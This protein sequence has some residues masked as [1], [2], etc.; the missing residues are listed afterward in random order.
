MKYHRRRPL[1]PAVHG[2]RRRR[3]GAAGGYRLGSQADAA[4]GSGAL[5]PGQHLDDAHPRLRE[6]DLGSSDARA[7]RA[8][9]GGHLDL[10]GA[11]MGVDEKTTFGVQPPSASCTRSGPGAPKHSYPLAGRDRARGEPADHAGDRS[12]SLRRR[13]PDPVAKER[14]VPDPRR[15]GSLRLQGVRGRGAERQRRATTPGPAG[16]RSARGRRSS[17]TRTRAPGAGRW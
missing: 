10:P 3:G 11:R 5:R 12:Q 16:T 17:S 1:Q 15:P 4:R 13:R 6:P 14:P 9:R 7:D 8:R 2:D